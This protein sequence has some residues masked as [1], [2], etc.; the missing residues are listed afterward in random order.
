MKWTGYVARK[1]KK[2]SEERDH[3]EALDLGVVITGW[4]GVDSIHLAQDTRKLRG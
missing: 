2:N 1:G 4:N 3:L